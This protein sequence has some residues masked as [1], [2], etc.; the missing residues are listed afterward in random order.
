MGVAGIEANSLIAQNSKSAKEK[1]LV[2][3]LLHPR[4]QPA[5]RKE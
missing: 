2:W 4:N 5:T 3:C 1:L